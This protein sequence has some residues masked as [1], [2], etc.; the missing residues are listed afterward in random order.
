MSD[1]LEL[2][3]NEVNEILESYETEIIE[4]TNNVH[5]QLSVDIK[6]GEEKYLQME[7]R[8]ADLVLRNQN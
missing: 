6:K 8:C 1:K 3:E 7:S 4:R 5:N 2:K